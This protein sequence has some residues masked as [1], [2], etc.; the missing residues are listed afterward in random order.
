LCEIG[1]V[2]DT[3]FNRSQVV[4]KANMAQDDHRAV[5]A[6]YDSGIEV[7][8]NP[9]PWIENLD[10][11]ESNCYWRDYRSGQCGIVSSPFVAA[12]A[13]LI[14]RHLP[15]HRVIEQTI[16]RTVEELKKCFNNRGLVNFVRDADKNYDLDTL[17]LI[18]LF[19]LREGIDFPRN[20]L[21]METI[22]RNR[23][24]TE[25]AFQTWIDRTRNNV[26]FMVNL[27][28]YVL[29]KQISFEDR[30]L[31]NYLL[32]N[33]TDFLKHGSPYYRDIAFPV[34]MSQ[35]YFRH[36]YV[37]DDDVL[38]ENFLSI[39]RLT[40]RRENLKCSESWPDIDGRPSHRK[41]P[42][43]IRFSQYFNSSSKSYHSP[44]LDKIIDLYHISL[45]DPALLQTQCL[46]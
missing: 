15:S 46:Q 28:I 21:V 7:S 29:F 31:N 45:V 2:F 35:F 4:S 27:S 37:Q 6:V 43:T 40:E 1:T 44:L 13:G 5:K 25:G 36:N 11:C 24:R 33:V 16:L 38:F 19:L 26:D 34:F 3:V 23:S 42:N 22:L 32:C 10:L 12:I 17:A 18:K 8:A 41:P 20:D 14:L 30:E 9:L 39:D